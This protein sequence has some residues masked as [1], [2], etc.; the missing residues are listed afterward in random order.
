M[1][2]RR[3]SLSLHRPITK[4]HFPLSKAEDFILKYSIDG[5]PLT[6]DGPVHL[7]FNDGSNIENPLKAISRIII[8]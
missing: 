4:K 1:K 8:N 7:I 3:K 2:M 5:K 6:E